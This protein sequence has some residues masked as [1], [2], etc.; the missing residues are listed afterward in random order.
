MQIAQPG[1]SRLHVHIGELAGFLCQ[2][3]DHLAPLGSGG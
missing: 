2:Q 3:I 1:Q